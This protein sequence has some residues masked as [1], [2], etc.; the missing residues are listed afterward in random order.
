MKWRWIKVTKEL[1]KDHESVFV[2]TYR[3]EI[4]VS[5]IQYQ[6]IA[7]ADQKIIRIKGWSV[8]INSQVT[9]WLS[10]PKIPKE[11]LKR[12]EKAWENP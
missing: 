8:M 7:C 5:S 3:G 1:P 2:L 11:I 12:I 4:R 10:T 6:N 9:H